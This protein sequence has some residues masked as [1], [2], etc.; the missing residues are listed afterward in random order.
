MRQHPPDVPTF[1]GNACSVVSESLDGIEESSRFGIGGPASSAVTAPTEALATTG[2]PLSTIES[3]QWLRFIAASLVVIYHVEVQLS[4]LDGIPRYD[5]GIGASGVD[6]FFVISG[7]IMVYIT[8]GRRDGFLS[9]MRRRIL[10]ILPIYWLGT[11]FVLT[12]LFVAPA[13]L[14]STTFDMAHV[15]SSFMFLPYPHPVSDLYWPLLVPGWTLNYEMFFYLLFASMIWLPLGPRILAV[16]SILALLVLA[17]SLVAGGS[18]WT[19]FYGTPIVLEFI[20]GMAIAWLYF[21]RMSLSHR[22]MASAAVF[23]IL[24]FTAGVWAGIAEQESRVIFWGLGGA[25][26]VLA[27]VFIEKSHGW[28]SIKLL[29]HLGD[30]SFSIYLSHLFVLAATTFAIRQLGIF[31]WLAEAGT[32]ALMLVAALCV[33]SAIFVWIERPMHNRLKRWA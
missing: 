24:M 2:A 25:G 18:R 10:R 4:R 31:P 13:L 6:I 28:P 32:R 8:H 27:L 16:S 21:T 9:F 20:A 33:G 11:L 1:S 14:H 15:V 17:R 3:L 29:R 26:V 19:D 23:G 5:L 7:F 22:Q 30:A 12:L